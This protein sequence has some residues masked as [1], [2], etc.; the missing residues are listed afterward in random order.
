MAK[1]THPA[2]LACWPACLTQP[3]CLAGPTALFVPA[4]STVIE[5]DFCKLIFFK[6]SISLWYLWP[7]PSW[8][9]SEVGDTFLCHELAAKIACQIV[10]LKK[11]KFCL[12]YWNVTKWTYTQCLFRDR[13]VPSLAYFLVEWQAGA[14]SLPTL[15][16]GDVIFAHLVCPHFYLHQE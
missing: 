15:P 2:C 4:T 3:T 11:S 13:L 9:K 7:Y 8:M 10:S 12:F 6:Q 1:S 14:V 16:L 5:V